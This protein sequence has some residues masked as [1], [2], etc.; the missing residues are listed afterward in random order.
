[1]DNENKNIQ[2]PQF[3][4]GFFELEESFSWIGDGSF[5][6]KASGLAFIK[7]IIDNNINPQE[8]PNAV[9]NIPKMVVLRTSIFDAFMER[10]NLFD[11]AINEESDYKII[12]EFLKADLPVEILGDLRTIIEKVK[13]PLAVRSSSMLED[14]KY[15]PFA[16]IYATKM[17]PN[18]Q[19]SL[20]TRFNKLIEAVKFVYAST[21][22]KAS[23][24]YFTVSSHSVNEEKMA[25]IIQEVVGQTRNLRYYPHISGVARSFNFYPS[26]KSKP[27][28]G[29]VNLALGLGKTIVDGGI[30]WT[31][32]PAYP[33]SPPPFGD[34]KD[35]LNTTQTT[36]WSVN[37]NTL[38]DY[39]P[40]K[41]T[42][43][44]ILNNLQ[45]ADYDNTLIH[46]AS[47]YD[48]RSNK[49]VMGVGADGPRIINFM[50]LLYMN[51]FGF[52]DLIKKI[53]KIS[54]D[55]LENPV[56]IEF[57]VTIDKKTDKLHFGFLQV[58]PMVVSVEE[59][60]IDSSE[61]E[62]ED[63]LVASNRVMGNGIIENISDVV[64]VNPDKFDKKF[65][66]KIALELDSINKILVKENHPY[67]LIG[68]GR[69]GS[70]DPWLGIPIDWS[71]IAGAK[72][73][74]ESTLFGINVELSQG[75]HFFHNLS[76]F[77]VCYF[78]INYDGK[79]AIDWEWL[80]NQ[81]LVN[82]TEF[83]R[84]VKLNNPLK[85]KVDGRKGLGVIKK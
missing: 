47:T 12:N 25:V 6:G 62:S 51:D 48:S 26:G 36:F 54:S 74:V 9:V 68:F 42:E 1:M 46:S 29:V 4:R 65:T 57:A 81:T 77:N 73:I 49:I 32:C 20:D 79:F 66:Q 23:K 83:V 38:V 85:I 76:S 70:S 84:H 2:L 18:N 24:V 64:F 71:Q 28:Q 39:D 50:P 5:G 59:V 7:K 72:V 52:N 82:E 3:T 17:I 55:A 37:M 67:L 21:F 75:S 80:N 16:G 53:M 22:F 19:P 34:P 60:E 78:S 45:E 43:F 41:E 61:L 58:R 15:E 44:L 8:F 11:F 30:V 27:E 69:W 56:E 31:Y 33:K 10:N 14:A 63:L 13:V 40:T 35:M